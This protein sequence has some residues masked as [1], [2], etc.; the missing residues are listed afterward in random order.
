MYLNEAKWQYLQQH[1]FIPTPYRKDR[2]G[3]EPLRL[4]SD[5]FVF[6]GFPSDSNKH[7][8]CT[9]PALADWLYVLFHFFCCGGY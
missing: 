4:L 3:F 6:R 2:I 5:A 7:I 9:E 1:L 8:E